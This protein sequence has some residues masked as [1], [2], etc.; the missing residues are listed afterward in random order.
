MAWHSVSAA[1]LAIVLACAACGAAGVRPTFRPFPE[2]IT[3]TVAGEPEEIVEHLAE[4]IRD[5]GIELRWVRIREGYVETKW[6]DSATGDTGGGRSLDT[7]G[8]IRLRFWTDLIMEHRSVVVGEA[9]NRRVVDPSLP[10]REMEIHVPQ[11]HVGHE[12]LQRI[13]DALASGDHG[14][15]H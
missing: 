2:A 14:H 8:V 3:D 4:L 15:E 10:E 9:V 5:E 11:D 6:F 12:I 7:Y 1:A 13:L